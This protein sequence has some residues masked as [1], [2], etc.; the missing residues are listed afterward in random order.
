MAD[1]CYFIS[2]LADWFSGSLTGCTNGHILTDTSSLTGSLMRRDRLTDKPPGNMNTVTGLLTNWQVNWLSACLIGWLFDNTVKT[3]SQ[4]HR[5]CG[6]CPSSGILNK[7]A[8]RKPYLF[9]SSGEGQETTVILVG[10][11]LSCIY[12]WSAIA[13]N[14][15]FIPQFLRYMFRPLRAIFRR[16]RININFVFLWRTITLQPI[17]PSIYPYNHRSNGCIGCSVMVLHKNTLYLYLYNI[18]L[19]YIEACVYN[20]WTEL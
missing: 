12:I 13:T 2:W 17:H 10:C 11:I 8:F 20:F 16:K 15:F 6:P 5:V 3:T 4:N 18:L 9:P 19:K 7:A 14:N 1:C